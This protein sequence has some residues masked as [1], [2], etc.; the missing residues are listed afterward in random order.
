MYNA[1]NNQPTKTM[2]TKKLFHE[3]YVAIDVMGNPVEPLD[4]IM[5]YESIIEEYNNYL[6]NE[7]YQFVRMTELSEDLQ[8]KYLDYLN[9]PTTIEKLQSLIDNNHLSYS[10]LNEN[11]DD[12]CSDPY[13]IIQEAIDLLKK[14]KKDAESS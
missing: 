6:A 5:H 7:G 12:Y 10:S 14:N 1:A 2:K 13:A 4:I 9:P 11:S 8:K 3:D